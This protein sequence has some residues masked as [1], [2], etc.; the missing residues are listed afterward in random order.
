MWGSFWAPGGGDLEF[1]GSL[2]K[3]PSTKGSGLKKKQGLQQHVPLGSRGQKK[4]PGVKKHSP[5]WEERQEA[6]A[7]RASAEEFSL[8]NH[9]DVQASLAYTTKTDSKSPREPAVSK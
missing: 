4:F 2:V 1:L 3:A 7:F 5:M 6:L 8:E 9:P